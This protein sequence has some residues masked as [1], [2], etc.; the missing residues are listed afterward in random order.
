MKLTKWIRQDGLLN[1]ETSALLV[2]DINILL[3][4]WLALVAALAVGIAKELWDRK[5]GGV[6]SW[7]DVICDVIGLTLGSL[8]AILIVR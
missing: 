7:H 2:V 1:I 3:K 8:I 5:H 4:L 6:A